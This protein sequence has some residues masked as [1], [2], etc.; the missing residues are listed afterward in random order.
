MLDNLTKEK[1]AVTTT[2][3]VNLNVERLA[4]TMNEAGLLLGYSY[5]SI[6]RLVK[7]GK[8]KTCGGLRKRLIAKAELERFLRETTISLAE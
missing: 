1:K 8:L 2:G 7:R 4:Y 3:T 6:W 5:L